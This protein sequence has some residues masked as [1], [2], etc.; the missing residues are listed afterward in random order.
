MVFLAI[1]DMN[2]RCISCALSQ[3]FKKQTSPIY[4]HLAILK[5]KANVSS[6]TLT[7]V[8]AGKFV[9]C[10]DPSSKL[11][12]ILRDARFFLIKSNNHENVS[13]AKAKVSLPLV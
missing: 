9:G 5:A 13:L 10:Q 7:L 8:C 3:V 6:S 1:P 2:S 11:R 12:Y 4:T